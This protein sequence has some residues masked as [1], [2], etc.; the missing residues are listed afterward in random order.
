MSQHKVT[1]VALIALVVIAVLV[2]LVTL[3]TGD[4]NT[5]SPGAVAMPTGESDKY[6][7]W[8]NAS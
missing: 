2:A 6:Q 3:F 7:E 1:L 5:P 8:R 4:G